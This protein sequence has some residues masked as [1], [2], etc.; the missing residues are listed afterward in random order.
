MSTLTTSIYAYPWDLLDEGIDQALDTIAALGVDAVHVSMSYHS[1]KF[2]SPR[3]LRRRVCFPEGGVIYFKMPELRG[4]ESP[5][6][7]VESSLADLE[8]FVSRLAVESRVRGLKLVAWVVGTHN[9]RLGQRHPECTVK[10]AY[11]DSYQYAL[12]PGN[13]ATR[14]YAKSIVEGLIQMQ[15]FD[16]IEVESI[17]YLGFLHGYHHEFYGVNLGV[18]EQ[19]LLAFGDPEL[20]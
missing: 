19:S 10:N 12:C 17:A 7:P 18:F 3:S 9:T 2:I 8:E 1:G 6:K 16:A 11:G 4:F 14:N 20:G 5:I 13:E 15:L